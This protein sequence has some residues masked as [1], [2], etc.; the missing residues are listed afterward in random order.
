MLLRKVCF[1]KLS[2]TN[3]EPPFAGITLTR[4]Y[5]FDLRLICHAELVEADRDKHPGKL[6]LRPFGQELGAKIGGKIYL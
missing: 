4:F 6:K 1:D 5:G 3:E 2:M